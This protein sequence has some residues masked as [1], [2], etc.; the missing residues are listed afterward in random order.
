MK[1]ST[2][3]LYKKRGQTPLELIEE[4]K[5]SQKEYLNTRIGYA[6]RLDPL[7]EGLILALV[8]EENK[9]KAFYENLDKTYEFSVL[10]GVKTDTYDL[11]GLA[12]KN[13][14]HGW[15]ENDGLL[16][17]DYLKKL[18][19]TR[20]QSYPPFSS[21]TVNGVPLYKLARENRL[22]GVKIPSHKIKVKSIKLLGTS[23]IESQKLLSEIKNLLVSVNGD[24]RQHEIIKRWEEILS[25]KMVFTLKHFQITASSGTYVRGI[26]DEMGRA[27]KKEALA[28]SIKRTSIGDYTLGAIDYPNKKPA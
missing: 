18:P 19:G 16:L 26:A 2:L 13:L 11:M 7:A 6:G 1:K 9:K 15:T 8:G 27:I 12:Q 22:S 23:H 25:Q 14:Y 28:F 17:K 5:S 4:F 10:F 20:E 21:R 24:F 3:L